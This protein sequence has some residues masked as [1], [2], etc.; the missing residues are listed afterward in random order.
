MTIRDTLLS[1]NY[2][3]I[4]FIMLQNHYRT[5]LDISKTDFEIAEK[6]L[7]YFYNTIIK[8]KNILIYI[9]MMIWL[10]II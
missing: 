6:H 2:E 9:E 4:K 10:V 3:T 8:A 1:Y 5:D 7:Y